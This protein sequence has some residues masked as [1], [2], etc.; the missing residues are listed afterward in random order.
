MVRTTKAWYLSAALIPQR[1]TSISR[2]VHTIARSRTPIMNTTANR[3]II[4]TTERSNTTN[5]IT[6]VQKTH[7]GSTQLV[8]SIIRRHMRTSPTGLR[9]ED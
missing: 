5:E 3:I 8:I 9:A 7:R 4:I 1:T 2:E 6:M